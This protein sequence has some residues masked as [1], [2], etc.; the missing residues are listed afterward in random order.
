MNDWFDPSPPGVARLRQTAREIT[1]ATIPVAVAI[2]RPVL[3]PDGHRLLMP[4]DRTTVPASLV[5]DLVE[6]GCAIRV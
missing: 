4:G 6:Y 5:D 1:T 3:L 2:L